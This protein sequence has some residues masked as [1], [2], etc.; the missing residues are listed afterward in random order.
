MCDVVASD[1]EPKYG[2]TGK[3]PLPVV[4]IPR[5]LIVKLRIDRCDPQPRLS[6]AALAKREKVAVYTGD[7]EFKAMGR[8]IKVVWL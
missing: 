2:S 7:P 4:F 8:E 1:F 6:A 5:Q 3:H